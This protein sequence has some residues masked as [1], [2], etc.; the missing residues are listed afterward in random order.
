MLNNTIEIKYLDSIKNRG[1][2][3]TKSIKKGVIIDISHFIIISN[4]DYEIIENTIVYDYI[5][6][7]IDSGRKV[8]CIILSF[9]QFINHSYIPNVRYRYNS[10]DKTVIYETI[11]DIEKGQELT[12][13]YN[14]ISDNKDPLWFKVL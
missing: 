13:N 4:K 2:L 1:I 3:A 9:T 12:V 5:F 6:E 8:R 11:K 10:R 7:F 14:G